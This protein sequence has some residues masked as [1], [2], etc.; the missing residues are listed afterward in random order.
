MVLKGDSDVNDD[1]VADDKKL[2]EVVYKPTVTNENR[3]CL[4]KTDEGGAKEGACWF[5]HWAAITADI[6]LFA[7]GVGMSWTS[8]VIPKFH[9][10]ENP[11]DHVVS[12]TEEAWIAA[13]TPLGSA[14]GPLAAGYCAD[15]LGR[16]KAL[17]FLAL[18]MI[19]GF[20]ILAGARNVGLY[21]FAR[22]LLGLGSGSA[23]AVVPMYVSEISQAYNR[24]KYGS[25]MGVLIT[26]GIIY[27][28]S[29]GPH[30]SIPIYSLTC[31][32]PLIIFIVVF[33][34]FMP[35]S[36][37][38]L[39]AQGN[40]DGA[41]KGL[42][43]LRKRGTDVRTEMADIKEVVD[44]EKQNTAGVKDLFASPAGRRAL[45]IS[46]GLV[47][48]QQFAGINPLLSF[49]KTIYEAAGSTI[50]PNICTII[51]GSVQVLSNTA[52]IFMVERMGRKILLQI[53]CIFCF[54]SM[55]VLGIYFFLKENQYDV[56]PVFWLPITCLIVYMLVFSFGL[57]PL[58]W[59]VMGEIFPSNVKGI[60]SAMTSTTSFIT[61]C[62]VTFLFPIL[63]EVLGM[64]G[65]F[66]LFAF[67]CFIGYFFVHYVL[68]E[69]KGKTLGEIQKFLQRVNKS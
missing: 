27:P 61:A 36:P 11:F 9:G 3:R 45:Y 42:K 29:I 57:G 12:T 58:P 19:A 62:L 13:F 15:K 44:Q 53:C 14:I 56:E 46:L 28:F 22:F 23:F 47:A 37:Y 16:K 41:D 7:A 50:P 68:F 66:W 33:A 39:I 63:S 5:L 30:L 64:A 55:T 34:T 54:L 67:F 2:V 25:A 48:L 24:G 35:E 4:L 59:T 43:K 17:L 52:C 49:M 60:A 20:L 51:T 18:P 69:T 31:A 26:L 1:G 32:V 40:F 21:Y 6:P 8:P 38:Y 65:G 10:E